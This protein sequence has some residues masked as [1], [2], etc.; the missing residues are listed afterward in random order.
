MNKQKLFIIAVAVIS[1]IAIA[2]YTLS[3]QSVQDSTNDIKDQSKEMYDY[4]KESNSDNDNEADAETESEDS[5]DSNEED[6]ESDIEDEEEEEELDESDFEYDEDDIG[7]DGIEEDFNY[8]DQIK[9][10]V[11]KKE[12]KK[13]MKRAEKAIKAY[14]VGDKEAFKDISTKNLYEILG[15]KENR[16]IADDKKYEYE[17]FPTEQTHPDEVIIDSMINEK[18][19]DNSKQ[20]NFIFVEE[21]DGYMIDKIV[22][23][24]ET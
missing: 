24:W 9:D 5:E 22:I 7:Y 2:F 18:D 3:S 16:L 4:T 19:E 14:S 21:K 12:Y 8:E 11:G 20:I 13:I 6:D 10:K 17:V 23:M 1:V 15:N